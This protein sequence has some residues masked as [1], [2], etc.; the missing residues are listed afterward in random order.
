L[1]FKSMDG[2]RRLRISYVMGMINYEAKIPFSPT[3]LVKGLPTEQN[4][5]V[6]M[7][8]LL[9]KIG[10]NLADLD[11]K[12]NKSEPD[13]HVSDSEWMTFVKPITITN[14]EWRGVSFRRAVDGISFS[15]IGT[16]G[17]GDIRFGDHG[18]IIK[19]DLSWRDMERE[20]LYLTL[21]PA[22]VIESLREGKAVQGLLMMNSRGIDWRTVKSV[23]VNQAWPCYYAGDRI[24]PSDSLEPFAVLDTVVD[25]GYG[26]VRVEIDCPII[27]ETTVR[28]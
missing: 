10:V 3:N 6:L 19:I 2:T 27:D 18:K 20:K 5:I 17:D 11:K 9:P 12:T 16:G 28:K 4:A 1:E 7:K 15:S 8:N 26:N 24:Q 13:F 22:M 23:T 14:T 25:T 21:A